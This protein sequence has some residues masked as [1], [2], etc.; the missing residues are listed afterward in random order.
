MSERGGV[1]QNVGC[2]GNFNREGDV[3]QDV[4]GD[5]E[6][7]GGRDLGVLNERRCLGNAVGGR[8]AVGTENMEITC[9]GLRSRGHGRD[10][11]PATGSK[12]AW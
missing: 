1:P 5:P 6:R 12:Q 11:E 10:E 9:M 2:S 3:G 8:R 4:V 7:R